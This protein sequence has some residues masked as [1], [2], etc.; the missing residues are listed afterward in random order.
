[1][2]TNL[3]APSLEQTTP[4][5][6]PL[7]QLI[8]VTAAQV[9]GPSFAQTAGSSVLAPILYVAFVQQMRADGS[10]LPRDR[11]PCLA[12]DV[13][14]LGI[15]PGFYLGRLA[16]TFTSLP[17]YEIGL[18]SLG[19]TSVTGVTVREADGIPTYP[20]VVNIA[21]D[22]STGMAVTQPSGTGTAQVA[23][24]PASHTDWGVLNV[25]SQTM[26][27]G[28]KTTQDGFRAVSPVGT[29]QNRYPSVAHAI[30]AQ[31]S[32]M[33]SGGLQ[34]GYLEMPAGIP[35][36]SGGVWGGSASA[37]ADNFANPVTFRNVGNVIADAATISSPNTSHWPNVSGIVPMVWIDR[38]S[39]AN[40]TYSI[41]SNA[42]ILMDNGAGVACYGPTFS[43]TAILTLDYKSLYWA[44]SES[45]IASPAGV[46]LGLRSVSGNSGQPNGQCNLCIVGIGDGAHN[47]TPAYCVGTWSAGTVTI[48][49]GQSTTTGGLTFTG[50]ILTSGS[51]SGTVTNVTASAP[52]SSSGGTTPNIT[53][54]TDGSTLDT[55]G[56]NQLEVKP[57]GIGATQLAPTIDLGAW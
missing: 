49:Y 1:M 45:S 51:L 6:P 26:G 56:S 24:T 10:L 19:A 29:L 42:T 41:F 23:S 20:N 47:L 11:E 17:V 9:V 25:V 7:L 2:N 40:A 33:V 38:G 53:L 36:P 30:A 18:A 55:N 43:S 54:A 46:A 8:R 5:Y 16:G 15:S 34:V 39:G 27:G 31:G 37:T 28:L 13:N 44:G 12:D 48:L 50:G 4:V 22:Q 3:N 52:L 21:F 32:V 57:G 35:S 14:G